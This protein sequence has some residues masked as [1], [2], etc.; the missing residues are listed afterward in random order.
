MFTSNVT[1]PPHC[2]VRQIWGKI[3]TSCLLSYCYCHLA[4]GSKGTKGGMYLFFF[5]VPL[6]KSTC[7]IISQSL[8]V[9]F[10]SILFLNYNKACS[11]TAEKD[12]TSQFLLRF[13]FNLHVRFLSLFLGVNF[14]WFSYLTRNEVT[15]MFWS[16]KQLTSLGK[17][18]QNVLT[19]VTNIYIY[20]FIY[21]YKIH[22]WWMER[23]LCTNEAPITDV[24]NEPADK[25]RGKQA[26]LMRKREIRWSPGQL[27]WLQL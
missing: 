14:G 13:F 4:F 6:H 9:S 11:T 8:F 16:Q 24:A 19:N 10:I 2:I 26:K 1:P 20:I 21:I 15:C 17:N 23:H 22:S 3:T 18:I 12:R 5:K 7:H 25:R 27:E